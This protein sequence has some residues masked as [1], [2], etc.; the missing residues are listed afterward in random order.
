MNHSLPK[1]PEE[2]EKQVVVVEEDLQT[3]ISE[4]PTEVTKPI[5]RKRIRWKRNWLCVCGSGLKFK[6]CCMKDMQALDL[7]DGNIQTEE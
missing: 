4:A 6:K 2:L 5:R 3:Q 1:L 7:L